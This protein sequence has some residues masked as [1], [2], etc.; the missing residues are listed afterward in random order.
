MKNDPYAHLK[1]DQY[2][3]FDAPGAIEGAVTLLE[4][5]ENREECAD[6]AAALANASVRAQIATALVLVDIA[7]T[8]RI[9]AGRPLEDPE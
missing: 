1:N 7:Q 8:L 2:G 3:R 6:P 9:L 5:S 4:H